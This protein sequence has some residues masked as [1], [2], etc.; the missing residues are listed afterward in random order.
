MQDQSRVR[1]PAAD[2]TGELINGVLGLS[3]LAVDAAMANGIIKIPVAVS[4][5]GPSAGAVGGK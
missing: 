5:V 4:K 2:G 1:F 3:P